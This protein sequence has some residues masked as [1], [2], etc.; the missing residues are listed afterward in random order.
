LLLDETTR[1]I[2]TERDDRS[3]KLVEYALAIVAVAS[4]CLL[5]V[6]R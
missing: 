2:A 5:A 6:V 4:A 1:E 3:M